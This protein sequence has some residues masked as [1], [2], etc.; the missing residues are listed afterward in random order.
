MTYKLS[1]KDFNN[2]DLKN[3]IR[4]SDGA[5]IPFDPDNADYQEYLLWVAEGNTADP[6]D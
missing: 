5:F 3:V 6:A 4:K 2:Q 1:G